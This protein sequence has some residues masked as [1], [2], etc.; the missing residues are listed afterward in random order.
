MREYETSA[1]II[2]EKLHIAAGGDGRAGILKKIVDEIA[3]VVDVPCEAGLGFL[4]IESTQ[5][6]QDK[7]IDGVE[8]A[9]RAGFE[10]LLRDHLL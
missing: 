3:V 6:G 10:I 5:T 9:M 7:W 2:T 4:Y 1:T 8:E